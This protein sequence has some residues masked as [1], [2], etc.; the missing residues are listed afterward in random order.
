MLMWAAEI[1]LYCDTYDYMVVLHAVVLHA[2]V[3]HAVVLHAVVLHAVYNANF[4]RIQ[5]KC[6]DANIKNIVTWT[7]ACV[8]CVFLSLTEDQCSAYK[9]LQRHWIAFVPI[10]L[11]QIAQTLRH[12]SPKCTFFF[13]HLHPWI[14]LWEICENVAT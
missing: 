2:V 13:F 5:G 4:W 7:P 1:V 9:K 8:F 3:L 10:K 6:T 12:Q 14:I 11:H